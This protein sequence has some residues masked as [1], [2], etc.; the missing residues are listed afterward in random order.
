MS[1]KVGL[2]AALF[3][4]SGLLACVQPPSVVLPITPI[5]P[6]PLPTTSTHLTSQ[7][8]PFI[9]TTT[10]SPPPTLTPATTAAATPF[11]QGSPS[12]A[13]G[14]HLPLFTV[15]TAVPTTSLTPDPEALAR[16]EAI[17]PDAARP[18]LRQLLDHPQTVG[19]AAYRVGQQAEGVFLNADIPMPLASVVKI[20]HL[21]AYA[22][23]VAAGQLNPLS[24]VSLAELENYYLPRSDLGAH[25]RAVAELAENGRTFADPPQIVLDE[26]P[27]LMIRHSSNAAT[28]YLHR[29]LGQAVI[30][31]TAI[32]LGLTSQTAPCPF[33]GQFLAMSNHVR[34]ANNDLLALEAYLADPLLYGQE[35][36]LLTDAFV[37]N[38]Q[39]RADEIAWLADQRPSSSSTQEF[40][41][42]HLNAQGSARDYA[43][44]MARLA[45]NGLS[46][47][48]SSFIARRFLEWPMHFEVNQEQ[49]YNLGY[50]NGRLPGSL[51]TVYYAYPVGEA[52]PIVIALFYRNLPNALYRNWRNSLPH[53]ELARWL[54]SDPAAL[55]ALREV[56]NIP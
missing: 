49:F 51:T 5:A 33:L 43:A 3:W 26:V 23:A 46:N 55:P 38:E 4:L 40:F 28:D 29:L 48:E 34:T 6:L 54:L 27:W 45:Q 11:F 22:E 37:T 32:S 15:E 1:A 44:L 47:G 21:V 24:A 14:Q 52:T 12:P 10:P 42:A 19:L 56:I 17:I 18:A 25:Q 2:W 36:I 16:L 35:V 53:D 39:F 20:I 8:T 7:T 41:T 9:P 50:K 13:C 31:Q 30:E